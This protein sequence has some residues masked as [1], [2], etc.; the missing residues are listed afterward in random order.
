MRKDYS[1]L[2][3]FRGEG[4]KNHPT[5]VQDRTPRACDRAKERLHGVETSRQL[6]FRHTWL[7]ADDSPDR[8]VWPQSHLV[9]SSKASQITGRGKGPG[10][11][12]V[13]SC[14]LF[15]ITE[16]MQLGVRDESGRRSAVVQGLL[17][18]GFTGIAWGFH[19]SHPWLG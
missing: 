11:S 17:A 5:T 7:V 16:I 8:R 18:Q 1:S 10:P 12:R 13:A 9:N 15:S 3:R 4:E 6:Q 14:Q 19:T 2:S